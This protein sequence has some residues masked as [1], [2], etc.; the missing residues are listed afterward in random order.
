MQA[1][2][3]PASMLQLQLDSLIH[4]TFARAVERQLRALSMPELSD[5]FDRTDD[6]VLDMLAA[7]YLRACEHEQRWPLALRTFGRTLDPQRLARLAR[8]FGYARV[9]LA[10]LQACPNKE[11]AYMHAA[12]PEFQGPRSL[13]GPALQALQ[14]MQALKALRLACA[15]SRPWVSRQ[16][17]AFDPA[18]EAA[19][20]LGVL[21]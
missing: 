14:A 16:P 1:I 5:W 8:S 11:S 17:Q 18:R 9:H 19:R 10:L 15:P 20:A 12:N 21:R 4:R 3:A 6:A 7:L 13:A 2:H